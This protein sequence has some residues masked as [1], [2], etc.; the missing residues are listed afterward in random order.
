[1]L[2]ITIRNAN[3]TLSEQ[4]RKYAAKKLGRLNRCH[5]SASRAELSH[6]CDRHIHHIDAMVMVEG[7]PLHAHESDEFC[8]AAIDRAV[9]KLAAQMKKLNK[10][11]VDRNRRA[12]WSRSLQAGA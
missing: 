8:H 10:R 12:R 5:N 3:G 7:K 2:E 6:R 4:D 1:M 9:D 11:A